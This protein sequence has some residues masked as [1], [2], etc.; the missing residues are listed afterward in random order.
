[1]AL[2]GPTQSRRSQQTVRPWPARRHHSL[3]VRLFSPSLA[4]LGMLQGTCD[5]AL[6]AEQFMAWHENHAELFSS[7]LERNGC[8]LVL[9]YLS[10]E[11]LA[12]RL[13]VSHAAFSIDSLLN[14][15][16]STLTFTC[17]IRNVDG[18]GPSPLV[19]GRS[20]A[21]FGRS[22]MRN[23]FHR[24]QDIFLTCGGDTVHMADYRYE[25]GWGVSG[26]DR[27]VFG[28]PREGLTYPVDEYTL[29]VREMTPLLGTVKVGLKSLN[30]TTHKP[31]RGT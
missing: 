3:L 9:H 24:S 23:S 5:R 16:R 28:F 1:M 10:P 20:P 19:D 26:D 31:L 25:R 8:E 11:Y 29:V 14:G 30:V 18:D 4:V 17:A 6:T 13:G 22:V 7:R 27:F 21:D 2:H 12:A 15:F